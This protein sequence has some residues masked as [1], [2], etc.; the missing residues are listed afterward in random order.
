MVS[1]ERNHLLQISPPKSIILGSRDP[2]LNLEG[3]QS[4]SL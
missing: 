1:L 4:F 2:H 3:T